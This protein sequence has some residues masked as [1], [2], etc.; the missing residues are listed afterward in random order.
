M[1]ILPALLCG[2]IA[3]KRRAV[4]VRPVHFESN[5][6]QA[7]A[8]ILYLQR[9]ERASLGFSE[10][11]VRGVLQSEEAKAEYRLSFPGSKAGTRP[12][13]EGLANGTSNI[14]KGNDPR[15]WNAGIK[16]YSSIRYEQLYA[17]IDLLFHAKADQLEYDFEVQPG[18]DA[19]QIRIRWSGQGRL[20]L[21]GSGELVWHTA[22]GDMV[23]RAPVA[24]QLVD[25]TRIAVTARYELRGRD[26]RFR[27]GGYDRRRILIIDPVLTYSTYLGGSSTELVYGMTVDTAGNMYIA[28]TTIS[29]NFPV[30][31]APLQKDSKGKTDAFITKLSAQGT[32]VYSTLLGGADTDTVRAITV[33][34][35]GSIYFAGS[36]ASADFPMVNARQPTLRGGAPIGSDAI[37]GKL[38]PTGSGLVFSS[39]WGGSYDE[40]AEAITLDANGNFYIA[41]YTFSVID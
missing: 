12:R 28:G 5:Q 9:A 15:R 24:Y 29:P 37:F 38:N 36:S 8:D 16:N 11:S 13:G 2:E 14:L 23:Q 3:A 1:G 22:A 25:G 41:G 17:G 6:G 39:F 19:E 35:Q 7:P 30:S 33:D 31:G 10:D 34:P 27:L 32:L 21:N 26:V 18:A 20:R 40:A 4:P